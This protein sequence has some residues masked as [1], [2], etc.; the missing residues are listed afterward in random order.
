MPLI[1]EFLGHRLSPGY[2]IEH[3]LLLW[4]AL[5][6]LVRLIRLE[7]AQVQLLARLL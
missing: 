6:G 7:I 3:L 2:G 4:Q 1:F 5:P